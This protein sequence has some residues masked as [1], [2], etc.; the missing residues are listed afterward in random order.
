VDP[1]KEGLRDE[2]GIRKFNLDDLYVRFFRIAERKIAEE[3]GKGIVCYISNHSWV[4]APSFER[5]VG[6][7]LGRT[8]GTG[9][10]A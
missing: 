9:A 1:Y 4:S 2:W 7:S 3:T 10:S 8:Q 5:G 6:R